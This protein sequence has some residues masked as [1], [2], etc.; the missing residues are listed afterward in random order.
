MFCCCAVH[1]AANQYALTTS[2]WKSGHQIGTHVTCRNW[3]LTHGAGNCSI[4]KISMTSGHPSLL[5]SCACYSPGH[6]LHQGSSDWFEH[7]S[8]ESVTPATHMA[9]NR[10]A[11]VTDPGHM[12][13]TDQLPRTLGPHTALPFPPVD[14]A[15]ASKQ[16]RFS[17]HGPLVALQSW[18]HQTRLGLAG[19]KSHEP[20]ERE[21]ERET[22]ACD[23][24]M[25]QWCSTVCLL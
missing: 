3:R 6:I 11:L 24:I 19:R 12:S 22:A 4:L 1:Q 17:I 9:V 15:M 16:S 7:S 21:R 8:T 5:L 10:C 2:D 13:G 23:V 18:S 20:T 25:L 14:F